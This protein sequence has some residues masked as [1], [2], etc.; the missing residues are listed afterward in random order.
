MRVKD[1]E[2]RVDDKLMLRLL[3]YWTLAHVYDHWRMVIRPRLLNGQSIN[4]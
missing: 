3:Q 1:R 4:G 2:K